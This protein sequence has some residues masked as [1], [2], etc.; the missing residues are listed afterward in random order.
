MVFL[1]QGYSYSCY[2]VLEVEGCV[3]Y[4][5]AVQALVEGCRVVQAEQHMEDC[6][7]CLVEQVQDY[8][9]GCNY[10]MVL[11]AYCKVGYMVLQADYREDYNR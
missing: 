1:V 10:Y 6:I 2:K 5:I 9:V 4:Y 8:T 11:Q 7:H 3:E